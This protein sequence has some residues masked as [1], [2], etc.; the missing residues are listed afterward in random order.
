MTRDHLR[1][2]HTIHH[3]ALNRIVGEW[4]TYA[5]GEI[6]IRARAVRGQSEPAEITGE[7][8]FEISGR[9][10][11][12]LILAADLTNDGSQIEPRPGAIIT[13]DSAEA[14]YEVNHGPTGECFEWSDARQVRLRI[15]TDR[16]ST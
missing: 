6:E 12:W 15:H 3:R 11:D 13:P 16:I 5:D 2:A 7:G 10:I 8:D 1:N 9:S 4:I 14:I